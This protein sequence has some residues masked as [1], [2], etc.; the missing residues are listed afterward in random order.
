MLHPLKHSRQRKGGGVTENS[1]FWPIQL[2]QISTIKSCV[3]LLTTKELSLKIWISISHLMFTVHFLRANWL[4]FKMHLGIV[5]NKIMIKRNDNFSICAFIMQFVKHPTSNQKSNQFSFSQ[6]E[7][8]PSQLD[9]FS[10]AARVKILFRYF[11][12]SFFEFNWNYC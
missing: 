1:R 12:S 6:N 9:R 4:N 2:L 11:V 7:I 5:F 10:T 3:C 8:S